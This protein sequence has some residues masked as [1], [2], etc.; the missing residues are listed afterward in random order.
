MEPLDIDKVGPG[1]WY[2]IHMLAAHS[3][4]PDQIQ[5]FLQMIKIVSNHFFCLKCREHFRKNYETF[6]PPSS[7]SDDE[8]FIWTVEMHNRVNSIKDKPL[9]SYL[10]AINYYTGRISTCAGNCGKKK[11]NGTNI[12]NSLIRVLGSEERFSNIRKRY[13]L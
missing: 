2:M 13:E 9:V 10:D 6:P 1:G 7:N 3:K 8:L 4:T 11:N 12:P 5:G